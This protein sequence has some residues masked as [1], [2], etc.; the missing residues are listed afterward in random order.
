MTKQEI[1]RRIQEHMGSATSQQ[2]AEFGFDLLADRGLVERS[3][4]GGWRFA[5]DYED[6][7]VSSIVPACIAAIRAVKKAGVKA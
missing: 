4:D 6:F 5:D 7:D 3:Y 1:T 2:V